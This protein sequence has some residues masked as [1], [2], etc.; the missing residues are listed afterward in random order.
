[1]RLS[2]QRKVIELIEW[3]DEISNMMSEEDIKKYPTYL[4]CEHIW[5]K[6]NMIKKI[7]N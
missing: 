6:K 5:T 4:F 1:M 3:V 7:R 2:F